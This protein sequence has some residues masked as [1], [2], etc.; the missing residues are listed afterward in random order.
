MIVSWTVPKSYDKTIQDGY[1][2]SKI[3]DLKKL[4]L[5]R[6]DIKCH[7]SFALS[8]APICSLDKSAKRVTKQS[9]GSKIK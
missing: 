6:G 9:C 5:L 2:K 8:Y 3:M 4:D 1:S 7:E